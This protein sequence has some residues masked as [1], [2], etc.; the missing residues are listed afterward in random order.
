MGPQLVADLPDLLARVKAGHQEFAIALNGGAYSRKRICFRGGLWRI[1]N[2]I[3]ATSQ[4]LTDAQ[5]FSE[6]NVGLAVEMGA[7]FQL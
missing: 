5:L 1:T 7:L 2:Y 4:S 3:D 6:S